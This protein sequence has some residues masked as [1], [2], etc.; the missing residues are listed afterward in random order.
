[1]EFTIELRRM[2]SFVFMMNLLRMVEN[3]LSLIQCAIVIVTLMMFMISTII[4]P[5]VREILL[6]GYLALL[7]AKLR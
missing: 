4:L 1:M 5:L 3:C 6:E 7:S 2:V